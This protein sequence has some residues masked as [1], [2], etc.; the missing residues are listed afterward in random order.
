MADLYRDDKIKQ[1]E[2][3]L[4]GLSDRLGQTFDAEAQEKTWALIK[5]RRATLGT[6]L[7][8]RDKERRPEFHKGGRS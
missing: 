1:L 6:L 5:D 7:L 2:R 4:K 3:E 8:A